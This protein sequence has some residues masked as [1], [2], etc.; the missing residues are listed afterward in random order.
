MISIETAHQLYDNSDPVHDFDHVLR[1]TRMAEHLAELE[2]ANVTVVRTAALLHDVVR[3]DANGDDHAVSAGKTARELLTDHSD[4]DVN[5]VVHAIEAHR[6]RNS[7]TPQ[8]IEAQVLFDADKLDAIGAIG[9][10]RVFAYAGRAG[11]PL[12]GE[13]SDDYHPDTHDE[14][15]TAQHEFVFKLSKIKGKLYT[16]SGKAIA[17]R[18]HQAMVDFFDRLS[19]EI[20]E[21]A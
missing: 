19:Q 7:I 8:T 2:G 11:N 6:F 4:D 1:V 15:H 16:D 13:V 5:A 21:F 9:I 3:H 12:W 14:P 20:T 18:R 10:A 17:E